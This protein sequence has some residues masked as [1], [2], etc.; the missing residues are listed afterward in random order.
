M[1]ITPLA[2]PMRTG[3]SS[4]EDEKVMQRAPKDVQEEEEGEVGEKVEEEWDH[5]LPIGIICP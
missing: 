4:E 2:V 3:E 1:S 5:H